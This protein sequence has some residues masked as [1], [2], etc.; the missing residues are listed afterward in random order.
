ME[1]LI[2]ITAE[3]SICFGFGRMKKINSNTN[4]TNVA[5]GQ[6]IFWITYLLE[7]TNLV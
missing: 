2:K 1:I 6:H 3:G 5:N 4:N 7:K